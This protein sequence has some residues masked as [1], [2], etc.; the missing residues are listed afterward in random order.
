[1]A[2]NRDEDEFK[3]ENKVK[4]VG[5]RIASDYYV[6]K[7]DIE[8]I[9]NILFD[10]FYI[11]NLTDDINL[12]VDTLNKELRNLREVFVSKTISDIK[13]GKKPKNKFLSSRMKVRL[14]TLPPEE[15]EKLWEKETKRTLKILYNKTYEKYLKEN[16]IYCLET[17][18]HIKGLEICRNALFTTP[19]R[20]EIDGEKFIEVYADYLEADESETKK[21][22]EKAAEEINRFFNNSVKITHKELSKYFILENGVI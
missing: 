14:E 19:S 2:R 8:Y 9:N 10:F 15:Q 4:K 3:N 6:L 18:H 7:Q 11:L 22:H 5:G 20:I 21:Q 13:A 1:M 17:K 12:I 16:G